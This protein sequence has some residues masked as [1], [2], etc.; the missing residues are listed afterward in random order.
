MLNEEQAEKII[1]VLIEWKTALT[2]DSRTD[3]KAFAAKISEHLT[4]IQKEY[5]PEPPM[6][7]LGNGKQA[8]SSRQSGEGA[9]RG[10]LSVL[11]ILD[12]LIEALSAL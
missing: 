7:G 4:G 3:G 6:G 12:E 8:E 2:S 11:L 10:E 5:R 1:P 9:P